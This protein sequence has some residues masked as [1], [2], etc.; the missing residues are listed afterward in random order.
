MALSNMKVFQDFA[1]SAMTET[2]DQQVN[3]FNSAS[4]NA[5]RLVSARNIGDTKQHASFAAISNMIRTRDAYGS[6]ALTGTPLAQRQENTVKIAA[7]TSPILFTQEQFS[8]IQQKPEEAG[9]VIGTQLAAGALKRQLN[10]AV[11]CA[12][13]ALTGNTNIKYTAATTPVFTDLNNAAQLFGDASQSIVAWVMHSS[14]ANRLW[15]AA[16]TQGTGAFLFK[17]ED[18]AVMQDPFGRLFVIT[19][20][21]ALFVGGRYQTLGLTAG[22]V[23]VEDNGDFHD[24]VLEVPGFEN[25]QTTYQAE[26]TYNVGVKGYSWTAATGGASPTDTALATPTNWTKTASFDKTTAGVLLIS[27]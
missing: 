23:L 15:N 8:Y 1:Y 14:V 22:G 17:Y 2:I 18:V 5:L 11:S 19:D 7:G 13:A 20:S 6:G 3:K 24:A 21:P 12:V 25:I 16:M 9:V 26:W 27:A 4:R 10:H